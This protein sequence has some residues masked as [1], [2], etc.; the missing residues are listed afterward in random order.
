MAEKD[1]A[2]ELEEFEAELKKDD[3]GESL[4]VEPEVDLKDGDAKDPDEIGQKA[5]PEPEPDPV[6]PV[7]EPK[8]PPQGD[9]EPEPNLTTL[10][11]DS[12]TFGELAGKQ[13][14]AQQLID[15]GLLGKLVTWGHQGRH[16][17]KKGQ[18]DIEA[19]KAETSEAQKLREL[20]ENQFAKEDKAAEAAIPRQSEEEYVGQL[21]ETYLAGLKGVA[22]AGGIE[23]DFVKEFPKSAVQIE[24]RF[25][26]G[27]DMLAVI[28]KEVNEL[29][30]YVGLRKKADAE[31]AQERAVVD[32]TGH[33]DGLITELSTKGD[34]YSKLSDQG[35]KEDFVKW[36]SSDD[37][38]LGITGK[39]VAKITE[40]DVHGAWLLYASQHPEKFAEPSKKNEEDARLAS[41]GGG[42]STSTTRTKKVDDEL[43]NFEK[44]LAESLAQREY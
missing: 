14:T 24:H 18:D 17:I 21:S 20:L 13:V 1:I 3:D 12:E 36:V 30:E 26:T 41:G 4:A 38:G 19:A 39:E 31:T 40:A 43:G 8:D 10:P 37:S 22:A 27:A 35:T 5:D 34:L 28:T 15:G 33:F 23:E 16:L 7:D 11:D 6:D 25:Q 44:E 42:S 9:P 32:A 29:R 2:D